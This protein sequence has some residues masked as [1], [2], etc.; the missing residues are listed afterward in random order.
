MSRSSHTPPPIH[1]LKT[2]FFFFLLFALKVG[3][4]PQC[5]KLYNRAIDSE[6]NEENAPIATKAPTVKPITSL[7]TTD[8]RDK[9]F[10]NIRKANRMSFLRKLYSSEVEL[11][12][13]VR[14]EESKLVNQLLE[15]QICTEDFSS[16]STV[17]SLS[18]DEQSISLTDLH[19]PLSLFPVSLRRQ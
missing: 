11:R 12:E 6:K 13:A 16:T 5:P 4:Y 2:I 18:T 19:L 17:R 3:A 1:I 8:F 15:C 14:K 9:S 7:T 10:R